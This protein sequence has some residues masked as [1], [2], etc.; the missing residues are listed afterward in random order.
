MVK[1]LR[2]VIDHHCSSHL[3][4]GSATRC[5]PAL[6]RLPLLL[7]VLPFPSRQLRVS[8]APVPLLPPLGSLFSA[9][10]AVLLSPHGPGRVTRGALASNNRPLSG[11]RSLA[12]RSGSVVAAVH[13]V[14]ARLAAHL[15][16]PP[17]NPAVKWDAPPQSFV[18]PS[19]G[20]QVTSLLRS[21]VAAAR[22]LLPR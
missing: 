16:P 7:A 21:S 9:S 13:P 14:R 20:G 5:G 10:P 4:A 11:S 19:A 18:Q 22:P 15:P 1:S 3:R 2:I 17:P 12:L 8:N 6:N